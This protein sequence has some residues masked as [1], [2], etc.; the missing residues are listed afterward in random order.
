MWPATWSEEKKV[1]LQA[2][3]VISKEGSPSPPNYPPIPLTKK[4]VSGRDNIQAK[5]LDVVS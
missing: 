1:R 2:D 3:E 5:D 4:L